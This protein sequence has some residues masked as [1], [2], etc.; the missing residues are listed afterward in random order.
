M[1][2]QITVITGSVKP[3]TANITKP[4]STKGLLCSAGVLMFFVF[5]TRPFPDDPIDIVFSLLVL[6]LYTKLPEKSSIK[7]AHVKVF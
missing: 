1:Y 6:L 7:Y 4:T 3:S 5:E 2:A